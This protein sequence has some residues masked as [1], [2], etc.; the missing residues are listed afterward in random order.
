L[1][2]NSVTKLYEA[3]ILPTL[4][5]RPWDTEHLISITSTQ[6]KF[7][8][9]LLGYDSA[10]SVTQIALYW[11]YLLIIGAACV[12]LPGGSR[13]ASESASESARIPSTN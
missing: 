10:P 4:G 2:A 6:G 5:V 3:A 9:T 11:G 1:L 8:S 13:P 7:L 12:F